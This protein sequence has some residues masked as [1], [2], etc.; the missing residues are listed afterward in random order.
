M[1]LIAGEQKRPRSN[2]KCEKKD[3]YKT[4]ENQQGM[5]NLK[6]RTLQNEQ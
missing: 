3:K 6:L 4:S 5:L 1:N 2:R